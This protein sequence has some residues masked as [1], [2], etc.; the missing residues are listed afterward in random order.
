VSA[1]QIPEGALVR[2]PKKR[3]TRFVLPTYTAGVIFY[4]TLPIIVM[5]VY[6]FNQTLG[7]SGIAPRVKTKWN[8]F[9]L[10]WYRQVFD[11]PDL[12][13]SLKNSLMI[14][15][16]SALIATVL[17][18]M[19]G[20]ALGRYR[21]RGRATTDFVLFLNISAP[22][23]VMG[24]SLAA[25]FVSIGLTR[26]LFTLLLSHVMFSIAYVAVTVRA[27]VQG[28]DR[29]LE[30]A[31]QDLGAGPITTFMKVTLPLIFPAVIAGG[32]LAFALSIDDFVITQFVQGPSVMF[33]TW[34]LGASRVGIPPQA[35]V[36][37]TLIFAG[38]FTL[39]IVGLF[40]Q[41]RR[42]A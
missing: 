15:V 35:F 17:G 3:W 14:A 6:S 42:P 18:T 37:A 8:G 39:A 1:I 7:G 26:G 33:P 29:S 19:I 28:L 41:K 30:N 13:H 27:R 21:Y 36:M 24:A 11:I 25:F 20:L 16:L 34:V 5:I 40:A 22:E 23:I 10:Q 38:G 12:T 31:A 2:K 9:T 4:I 32:L